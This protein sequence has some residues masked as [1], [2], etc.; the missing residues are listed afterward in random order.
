MVFLCFTCMPIEAPPKKMKRNKLRAAPTQTEVKKDNPPPKLIKIQLSGRIRLLLAIW[1]LA[2]FIFTLFSCISYL[3]SWKMDQSTIYNF[4]LQLLNNGAV[5]TENAMGLL[6]ARW[7]HLLMFNGFGI[8]SLLTLPWLLFVSLEL[9]S[10]IKIQ[11][12]VK[13]FVTTLASVLALSLTIGA[14]AIA[15]YATD[16]FNIL[17][18]AGNASIR[19]NLHSIHLLGK[20][21]GPIFLLGAS[22]LLLINTLVPLK[23]WPDKIKSWK[24]FKLKPR[25]VDGR[26]TRAN[27]DILNLLREREEAKDNAEAAEIEKREILFDTEEEVAQPIDLTKDQDAASPEEGDLQLELNN[28]GVTLPLEEDDEEEEAVPRPQKSLYRYPPLEL[29]ADH[30]AEKQIVTKEELTERKDQIVETLR[31]YKIEIERITATIGPTVTLFEIVPAKG[32]RISKIKNLEDD[33][34]LSLAALGIRII[35]PMPGKGTIGI[36]V[37]N[38]HPEIVALKEALDSDAYKNSKAVLPIILGKTISNEHYVTDLTKMPHLLIAGATGQG[39]SVGINTILASLLYKKHPEELKLIL[40]DPK[41]VELSLYR[42]LQ[43]HFLPVLPEDQEAVITD[44]ALVVKVLKSLCVEMDERYSM[45]QEAEVKSIKEYN[46][47]ALRG[48]LAKGTPRLPYI[49]LVIDELADLMMTAGKEVEMPIARLAQLARAIGIHLIVATQRPSVN[50]ITGIIKANFPARIAFRVT[51]KVDSR[52]ILDGGGAE[53]LIG[54]G[55]MLYSSGSNIIRLQCPFIDTPEV[56]DMCQHISD[57]P[58]PLPY[59]LHLIEDEGE[60]VGEVTGDLDPMCEEAARLVVDTQQGSTS[61]LQRRLSLGY[62][63]AGRVMDQLEKLKIV[64]PARGSKP[65]EVLVADVTAL[66]NYFS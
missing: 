19:L 64:G 35:A 38:P 57:Q 8:A 41:K 34:A 62:N 21:G 31:N 9:L 56:S 50:I 44:T 32:I 60:D 59:Y 53:Q 47:K 7:S 52:T 46:T 25:I 24:L 33:I 13:L 39:K 66:S 45:L 30:D 54:R 17:H 63:R 51:S 20:V 61:M 2:L 36:E 18:L 3:S 1:L 15:A 10:G 55:D 26:N 22:Y 27:Q 37:P 28:T 6:G 49:V 16:S 58:A 40:I 5:W 14:I 11:R 4:H 23:E 29:L 12:R 65:R 48:E 43:R 42:R